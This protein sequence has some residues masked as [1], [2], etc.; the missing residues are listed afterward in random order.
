MAT[1]AGV[2]VS[3][4]SSVTTTA[5]AIAGPIVCSMMKSPVAMNDRATITVAPLAVMTAPMAL[6]V[7][8]IAS[9]RESCRPNSSRKRDRMKRQ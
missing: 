8:M 6:M 4:A 5:S 2:R 3:P 9:L 7:T 1:R